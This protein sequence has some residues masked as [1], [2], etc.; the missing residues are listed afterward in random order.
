MLLLS[1][2]LKKSLHF[3]NNQ[4]KSIFSNNSIRN[5][6][7]SKFNLK[8]QNLIEKIVQKYAVDLKSD[9]FIKSGDF[10]MLKPEHVMTHDNTAPVISK[11]NSIGASK[12]SNPSQPVFTI[13]HDVQN[14]SESNLKKYSKI[15]NFAHQQGIDFYP[16]GRGIGHQIMIEEGYAFPGTLMVAS[17]SHSNMYGGVGCL[18]TPVVR[19]DAASIWATQRTWWQVP[20]IVKVELIGSLPFGVT[21][22]DIIVS[23]CGSFNQDQVLNTAIEFTGDQISTLTIDE[24]LAI[25][26]MTTEW[27][28]LAGVFPIDQVLI[29]WYRDLLRKREL[30]TFIKSH[31]IPSPN[32]GH[33]RLSQARVDNL[34][35]LANQL[36]PDPDAYY[37]KTLT[38][39]LSTLVPHVSGPN[40]VKLSNPLSA[41]ESQNI[42]INKAY[43]LSCVNSRTSDLRAAA[44][45]VKGK[46]VAPGVEF[47]IAAASSVVQAESESNGDWATLVEAGAKVLPAGCGP[48]IGLGTGLLKEGE[49]GISAT[50]R[51][52]KGR[53]GSPLAKA[54]LASPAVVAASAVAGKICGPHQSSNT[55][56]QISIVHHTQPSLPVSSSSPS[57]DIEPLLPSFP[58]SFSGP[59]LFAPGDNINTDGIYPGKYTYQDDITAEQQAKVV[60]ENYDPTF[61]ATVSELF[62]SST[63]LFTTSVQ[64]QNFSQKALHSSKTGKG[65]ILV[66]GYNF[67]TGSSR[68]QAATALKN[69]GIP[70]VIGGS[71]SDIFK[72]NS[73]NNG[74]ICLESPQLVKT[75]NERF[76]NSINK[77]STQLTI[78]TD[79]EIE[80]NCITSQLVIKTG[81]GSE[82]LIFPIQSIGRSVQEIFLAG[83]L[84]G[85]VRERI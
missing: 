37:S 26:N 47:Y 79:W 25:S 6:S 8:N 20:E 9:K 21:G 30:S 23:L 44:E 45:V 63:E 74:L 69:S 39:D 32:F 11:F 72:R 13:D 66:S 82:E 31:S 35:H 33:P 75:L 38:L 80:L 17:D 15:E 34:N 41:L 16:P 57:S 48:C 10:V 4:F 14:K 73:I 40:S 49:V 29:D 42:P 70:V 19:T 56:P 53:M 3:N 67:G 61:A 83:G 12:I 68:E 18:G 5:I 1:V 43:L 27:G 28:A 85:W 60:M 22:K 7:S 71:F 51:N 64:N 59:L 62:P 58:T 50:N 24:R 77:D 55:I 2:N 81:N 36:K 65:V 46:S 54:Y 78:T 84:E 52:Y 76:G